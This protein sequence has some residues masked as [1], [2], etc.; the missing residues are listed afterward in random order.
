MNWFQRYGIPGAVF[1]GF[2]ILWIGAFHHYV[3][4]DA[5]SDPE[6]AKVI[7]AIAAGTFLPIGYLMA[8]IGQLIY[9]LFPGIGIDT[10]VRKSEKKSFWSRLWMFV[11]VDKSEI[12][13]PLHESWREWKQEVHSFNQIILRL[14]KD[15]NLEVEGTRLICG[16]MSKRMDM[17]V[18]NFASIWAVIV[19]IL[20][21]KLLGLLG[22]LPCQDNREWFWLALLVSAIVVFLFIKSRSTLMKQLVEIERIWFHYLD[23]GETTTPDETQPTD[24]DSE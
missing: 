9:H 22:F 12:N 13:K 18:I 6:K 3:I 17:V 21:S 2:L 10:R 5:I 1:W 8:L 7:A 15:K 16:W 20:L 4:N 11:R 14:Y 24:S 19:A 23:H